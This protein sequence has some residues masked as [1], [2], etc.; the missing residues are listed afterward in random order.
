M[1][2]LFRMLRSDRLFRIGA[3]FA[4]SNTRAQ[5]FLLRSVLGHW[6]PEWRSLELF[7]R[8][9]NT[10]PPREVIHALVSTKH[11]CNLDL[12][13][14][15]D[16][17]ID[18][19]SIYIDFTRAMI[20]R[21]FID[22]Y[23]FWR[24]IPGELTT[25]DSLPQPAAGALEG[26]L[27]LVLPGPA[28]GEFGAEIDA[29]DCVSRTSL[30]AP[31]VDD[32]TSIGS[33]FDIAFL[34]ERRYID[35]VRSHSPVDVPAG[36][37]VVDPAL[38]DFRT[39]SW[40]TTPIAFELEKFDVPGAP[41]AYLP[42][43]IITWAH[44]QGLRPTLYCADFYLGQV[45]YQSA[46]Y[47]QTNLLQNSNDFIRSYLMHDVFFAHAAFQC[48]YRAGTI[49]ARGR[50]AEILELDGHQFAQ[51]LENRWRT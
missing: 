20:E 45:T 41:Y 23:Q 13:D 44:E 27:A 18:R 35:L 43:R 25:L 3:I 32:R 11:A 1:R 50:L 15:L 17:T 40:L 38:T 28:D 39:P 16:Q 10:L 30:L 46:D 19:P 4:G 42:L 8:Y 51:A 24:E 37:I 29:H 36:R 5:A 48:W 2:R 7:R 12:L 22:A 49:H 33:R 21:R 47:N 9:Q 26:S 6:R 34:A 31:T 14:R